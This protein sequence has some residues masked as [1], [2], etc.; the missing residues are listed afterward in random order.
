MKRKTANNTRSTDVPS[1]VVAE[2]K[3]PSD[4]YPKYLTAHM[5]KK[6][7]SLHKRSSTF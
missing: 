7:L 4:A 2:H 5:K 1:I 6:I 3:K